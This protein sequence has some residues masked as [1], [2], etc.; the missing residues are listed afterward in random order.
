MSEDW[1]G[2]FSTADGYTDLAARGE[3]LSPLDGRYRPVVAHLA[4][5]LSEAALNRARVHVDST[6]PFE[7]GFF[8]GVVLP[9]GVTGRLVART[10]TSLQDVRARSA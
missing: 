9:K 4:D 3:P 6:E 2:L 8:F 7:E 10:A 1:S 5:F